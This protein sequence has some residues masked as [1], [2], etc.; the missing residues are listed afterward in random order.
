VVVVDPLR[1]DTMEALVVSR[2]VV[3]ALVQVVEVVALQFFL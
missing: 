3:E 1:S 2:V